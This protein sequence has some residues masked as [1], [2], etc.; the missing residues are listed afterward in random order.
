MPTGS[1]IENKPDDEP[2]SERVLAVFP[3]AASFLF[4]TDETECEVLRRLS[5]VDEKH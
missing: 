5:A 2:K 4:V 3:T 1:A